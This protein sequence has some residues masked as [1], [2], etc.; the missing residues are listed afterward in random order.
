MAAKVIR[1]EEPPAAIVEALSCYQTWVKLPTGSALANEVQSR[2]AAL[3]NDP[4][5]SD[6]PELANC[7]RALIVE[8]VEADTASYRQFHYAQGR[9]YD[10]VRKGRSHPQWTV[11]PSA[12]PRDVDVTGF[13]LK[14]ETENGNADFI[15]K[16]E[17]A[18]E[19]SG[20]RYEARARNKLEHA[21]GAFNFN[22]PLFLGL[23]D[24]T[25]MKM[26]WKENGSP[27]ETTVA[28]QRQS[29]FWIPAR[30]GLAVQ[31]PGRALHIEPIRTGPPVISST[32]A[33]AW[34]QRIY[35]ACIGC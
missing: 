5:W 20:F 1:G 11:A 9:G 16:I 27:R 17:I 25:G 28:G 3:W 19:R 7:L 30:G 34:S 24:L 23:E 22:L 6:W 32:G 13:G 21:Y 18:R 2:I 15:L 12:S 31:R 10:R 35:M 4:P 26:V 33:R 8:D 14:T 29:A